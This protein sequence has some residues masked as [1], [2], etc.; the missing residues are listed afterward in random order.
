LQNYSEK[1]VAGIS[2]NIALQLVRHEN[3]LQVFVQK[4]IQVQ[5]KQF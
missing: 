2:I 4:T 3:G 5:L 1:H